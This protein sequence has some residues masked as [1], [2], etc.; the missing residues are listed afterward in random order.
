LRPCSASEA[1]AMSL[2]GTVFVTG[3]F[4]VKL[5]NLK[6]GYGQLGRTPPEGKSIGNAQLTS[7]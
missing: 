7:T 2:R 6:R 5:L 3:A 4:T 1:S